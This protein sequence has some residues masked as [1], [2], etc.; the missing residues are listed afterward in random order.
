M[1]NII[2]TSQI[3]ETN[4]YRTTNTKPILYELIIRSKGIYRD[5]EIV[6]DMLLDKKRIGESEL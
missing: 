1:S 4:P 2:V 3:T 5:M 6:R